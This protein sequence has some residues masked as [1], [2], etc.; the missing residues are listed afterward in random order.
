MKGRSAQP[1]NDLREA[2]SSQN[3]MNRI[4]PNFHRGVHYQAL[5]GKYGAQIKANGVHQ[6]LGSFNTPEQACAAYR[7]A[8]D[9][10]HL[11]FKG[12]RG[13]TCL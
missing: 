3:K 8:A 13:C 11:E 2:T 7:A 4:T 9:R 10:L 1:V 5:S 12:P 6:W